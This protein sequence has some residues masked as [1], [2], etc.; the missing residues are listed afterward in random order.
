MRKKSRPSTPQ[1]K[2]CSRGNTV[3]ARRSS[4]QGLRG[5]LKPRKALRV[6]A[7]RR[8]ERKADTARPRTVSL[9]CAKAQRA[10][11]HTILRKVSSGALPGLTASRKGSGAIRRPSASHAQK[12]AKTPRE[13]LRRPPRKASPGS[14]PQLQP[15]AR[16]RAA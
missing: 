7:I 1:K 10:A 12:H 3:F 16:C 2:P 4:P 5:F 14:E 6:D 13:A 15:A 11:R 8:P 9:P